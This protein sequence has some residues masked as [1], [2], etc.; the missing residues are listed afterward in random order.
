MTGVTLAMLA[1]LL[2]GCGN[3]AR[4]ENDEDR[5]ITASELE[6]RSAD[7]SVVSELAVSSV[8]EPELAQT[9]VLPEVTPE[10]TAVEETIT[11][12]QVGL[13]DDMTYASYSAIHTGTATLYK[14]AM[15]N[16][17]GI[18]VCVNAGHGTS[19]GSS[20]QTQCH[21]DGSAKVTGGSTA[22][23][24]TY[25]TAVSGGTT[26]LDGTAESTVTLQTALYLK[27]QLLNNGYSVLMIRETED[28]Q[29]DN[30]ARTVLA[31]TYADC[32]IALHWDSTES[33]KGAFY[34]K[35]P[36]VDS[37]KSMEPVASTW[38]KSDQ[39][40]ECLV[41]GLEEAGRTIMSGRSMEIDLTQ[42]SY[43]SIPSIDIE[44]GDRASDHSDATLQ[45]IAD[46]LLKGVDHYFTEYAAQFQG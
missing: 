6:K 24:S 41:Q 44:L 29:L 33:D 36:S 22:A 21:P 20:A 39:F 26:F 40:G 45:Q 34:I 16:A 7:V 1:A 23:G 38:Q 13:T 25:A 10:V 4:V 43:S 17:K 2:N 30:V 35:V 28:V 14:N 11:S 9:S 27:D 32:H 46:G 37:F 42:T 12:E 8:A 15:A 31:N 5:I 18:T 19:G 3:T